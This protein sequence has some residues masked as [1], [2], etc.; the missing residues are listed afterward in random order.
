MLDLSDWGDIG[1]NGAV[2]PPN[3]G[4]A[5]G[6]NRFASGDKERG[7][8]WWKSD[9]FLPC[10]GYNTSNGICETCPALNGG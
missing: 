2:E 1:V 5:N 6:V 4:G 8:L 7:V 9:A 10:M 3:C